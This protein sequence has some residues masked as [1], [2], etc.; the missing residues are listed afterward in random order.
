MEGLD[1]ATLVK[2]LLAQTDLSINMAKRIMT[3]EYRTAELESDLH[4]MQHQLRRI[5]LKQQ[6]PPT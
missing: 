1:T 3:Y 4:A 5:H 6:K 2:M